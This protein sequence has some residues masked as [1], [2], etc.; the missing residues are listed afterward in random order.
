MDLIFRQ[1][2][3]YFVTDMNEKLKPPRNIQEI[4]QFQLPGFDEILSDQTLDLYH[5]P[6]PSSIRSYDEKQAFI[7]AQRTYHI[8]REHE[9][10]ISKKQ[11]ADSYLRALKR[12]HDRS[13]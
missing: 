2:R 1:L 11:M 6:F 8:F 3:V 12:S 4:T 9:P 10:L 5:K 7:E 13:E